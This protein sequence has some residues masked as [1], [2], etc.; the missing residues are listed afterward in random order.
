MQWSFF[1]SQSNSARVASVEQAAI[2]RETN[3]DLW[4]SVEGLKDRHR[5]AVLLRFKHH[6]SVK[7]IAEIMEISEKTVYNRLYDAFRK[8]RVELEIDSEDGQPGLRE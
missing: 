4:S 6:L 5:L 8:L 2:Q 7:E 1:I 3:S